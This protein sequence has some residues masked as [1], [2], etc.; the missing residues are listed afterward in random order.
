MFISKYHRYIF[1]ASIIVILAWI[2]SCL[3]CSEPVTNNNSVNRTVES[4]EREGK[5]TGD[6]INKSRGEIKAAED[7]VRGASEAVERS[8]K[9]AN[10][11]SDG[12]SDC[13]D[14]AHRSRKLNTEIADILTAIEDANRKGAQDSK[15]GSVAK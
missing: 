3:S 6:A 13:A 5:S 1:I 4:L 15:E 8:Q 12:I 9:S 11:I 2:I 7:S 14:L 10:E